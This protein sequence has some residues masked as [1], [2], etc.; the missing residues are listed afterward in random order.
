M[1]AT[2]FDEARD[3]PSKGEKRATRRGL[4]IRFLIVAL[5]VGGLGGG[6]WFFNEFRSKAI[7]GFFASNVPPPT[8]VSAAPAQAGPMARY[9]GG[10]GSLAAIRQ[11]AVSPEV[12]GRV[13]EILFEPGAVARKGDPLVQLNDAPERADLANYEAQVKLAQAN[14]GRTQRLARNDFAAQATVDQNQALL[15]QAQAGIAKTQALIE[16][17][18]VKASF[19]GELGIRKVEYGQQVKPGDDLV[20]LTDIDRLYVN[21]TVPEQARAQVQ[22]G[23]EV[24]VTVDAYPGRVFKAK[25]LTLEPQIDP[26]TRTIRLQAKMD[27][28]DRALLP[29]MFANARLV[30]PPEPEVVTVPE[31]AVTRTLYGDS[32]FIVREE[33]G[34][35][36]GQPAQKAVQTQV[37][38]G[39]VVD[40]RVAILE[41]VKPGELVVS[42]GQLRLQNGAAVRVVQDT[43]LQLP[44]RPPVE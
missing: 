39:D 16:Q 12:E 32:I 2:L 1:A 28:D 24:E 42:S 38:T 22:I 19:D 35:Q 15:E 10:I 44:A 9:L 30:L 14:L 40:G 33:G 13:A 25:L 34:G 43:A 3:R 6:L 7:A 31:T 8:P 27:N 18:L 41:G 20:T 17:K 11:V 4:V 5:L 26:S 29:G 36:N 23:Q 21:F 37:R